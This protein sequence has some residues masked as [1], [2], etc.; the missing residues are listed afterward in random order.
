[1]KHLLVLLTF[2]FC[3]GIFIASK[4]KITFLPIYFLSA[5]VLVLGFLW[6]KKKLVFYCFLFLLVFLVGALFLKNSRALSRCHIARQVYAKDSEFYSIRGFVDSEPFR[7]NNRLSFFLAA[8][9]IQSDNFKY[10]CCGN[11]LVYFKGKKDLFYGDEL[12][13][14]GKLYWPFNKGYGGRQSYRG[15][16]SNQ[17]IYLVM[18]AKTAIKINKDKSPSFKRFTFWLKAKMEN[19]MFKY[20]SNVTAG[21]LDAMILG[22]RRNIPA[23][24]NNSMVKTG[25]VHIL[26]RQCTKISAFAL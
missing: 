7:K 18:N 3:L 13:L 22:E 23:V 21:I 9:E 26:A 11:I 2:V 24:V 4:I 25:T 16:L 15:Y 19:I 14:G 17:G 20:V 5:V 6:L 10:R 12:V 8:R 1:M